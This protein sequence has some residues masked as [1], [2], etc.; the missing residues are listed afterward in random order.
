MRKLHQSMLCLLMLFTLGVQ[1]QTKEITGKVTDPSGA[2]IPSATIR[3]KGT[4]TGTSAEMDGTFKINVSS[5]AILVISGVGYEAKEFKTNGL[6]TLSAQ[7]STESKSLSEVVVTGV[8][9]ATSKRH[10]GIA[11]ESVTAEN[12][13]AAPTASIDQALVGKIAGAQISSISGNPGDPVNI[14]LRGINTV[15]GGTKPLIL[16]DGVEVRATDINSLDLSNIERVEVVKGAA[17][18][19]M[20]GA[21]GANGVIQII[22]KKG[23]KGGTQINFSSSYSTNSYINNGNVH[24][25]RLHPYMVDGS[26]NLIDKNGAPLTYDSVGNLKG[27]IYTYGG[28]ARAGIWNPRNNAIHPYNANIKY[29]DQFKEVFQTGT[30]LN[31]ILSVSGASDKSDYAI[32]VSNNKTVTPVLKNGSVDR[33]NLTV[34]LGTEVFKGFKVRSVTQLVYTRNTL[35]PG[36]GAAGGWRYGYGN[37]QGSVGAIYGFLNTSPFFDLKWQH[38]NAP[39]IYG[40]ANTPGSYANHVQGGG[41]LSIN[42]GN[43]YY[44]QEYSTGLN[45]KVDVIQSFDANYSPIKF[46]E[47]DAKYGTNFR[48]ENPRCSFF[49]QSQNANSNYYSYTDVA[50]WNGTDNTGEIDNFQYNT[51]FQNFLASATIKTDFQND[52]HSKVPITTATKEAFAYRKN[53]YTEFDTYG[54]SLQTVPPYSGLYTLS[55]VTKEDYKEPF[56]TYGYLVDQ[57]I[58]V[59]DYAG[60]ACGF[61]SDWSSAF[62]K[63]SSP[64]TFPHVNGYFAPSSFDFWKNSLPAVSYFKVRAAYGEPGIQPQPFQRYPVI[65]A[66]NIGQTLAYSLQQSPSYNPNLNVEVTKE[67]EVGTDFSIKGGSGKFFTAFNASFRYWKRNSSSVIYPVPTPLSSGFTGQLAKAITMDAHGYEFSLNI[68]VIRSK[69]FNWDFTTTW[70]HQTSKIK[71]ILGGNDIILTSAA[72]SSALA[73]KPNM[74]IGQI[75]G[76]KTITSSSMTDPNGNLYIATGTEGRYVKINGALLDTGTKKIQYTPVKFDLA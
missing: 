52:F 40:S 15:Q 34:N 59:G 58:N 43:P 39:T 42:S 55:Q 18:S 75:Y 8:G 31:N 66:H 26:N 51:T 20:Y 38:P 29:Y 2:P 57:T 65:S 61:R 64:F 23:K 36:L 24:K 48:N 7:L 12:L 19:T 32:T 1:A 22:T 33:T 67:T 69:D 35:T 71:D 6:S 21:Q 60:I 56:V 37:A 63:G 16:V 14:V 9:T 74:T 4:K 70:G 72:G 54:Y 45:N 27:I 73:L 5:N 30:T 50:Y 53:L 10:L 44:A 62:G 68:P 47:L 49:N 11:V 28:G 41:Y 76:H 3:I 25:A 13:P 17:S 46:L